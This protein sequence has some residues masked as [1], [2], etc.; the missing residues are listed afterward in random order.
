[1]TPPVTPPV[2]ET[3]IAPPWLDAPAPRAA[4]GLLAD[5]GHQ[6][7]Y[8]GGCVRNA[9]IGGPDTDI[10]VATEARPER[11]IALA[12][13]AGLRAVPTGIEHG[14]VTLVLAGTPIEVTTFRRD[15]ETFGR[16]AVV[17]FSEDIAEDAARRDFTMNALYADPSGRVIDP[18]GGLGDLHARR[19]RF[20]GDPAARIAED[21]LRILRF[22][23]FH[24]WY[25]DPEAGLDADGLAACTAGQD[26]L[27]QL[28][29]ERLGAETVKLLSARDPA[30]AV[31]AMDASGILARL[32]PGADASVLAPLVHHEAAF[33]AA[34]DWRRRLAALGAPAPWARRLRLSRADAA[35][36]EAI[37]KAIAEAGP[38][39]AAY[40]FGPEAARDAVLI[41]AAT[42][43]QPLP[44]GIPAEIARGAAARFPLRA[45]DLAPL[46]GP[47]LGA[48][49]RRLEDV[50]VAA[51]F[52]P[53][54][55][56][57]IAG[58]RRG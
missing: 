19:V 18:L 30:P 24:A 48:E 21:Y 32:L 57:L 8:V 13:A 50:W 15:V 52:A 39:A 14:T 31:A 3:R 45:A 11:V 22:F 54:R 5:A 46:A 41:R 35:A 23:R 17:A 42:L 47:A 38:A 10:D 34:P 58:A 44:P 16:H 33:G 51:D 49:L 2:A 9:L 55:D 26:G 28:S 56:D 40:R 7:L 6:A 36:L 29:R 12:E 4:T 1:V 25:G 37:R 20:V 27:G 53:G 43:S